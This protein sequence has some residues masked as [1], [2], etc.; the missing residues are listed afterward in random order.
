MLSFLLLLACACAPD[1]SLLTEDPA[2][3]DRRPAFLEDLP[4]EEP[5]DT[6]DPRDVCPGG[7]LDFRALQTGATGIAHVPVFAPGPDD[8]VICAALCEDAWM[9]VWVSADTACSAEEALPYTITAGSG[10]ALCF[11]LAGGEPS[12]WRTRCPVQHSPDS[13]QVLEVTW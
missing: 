3:A 2:T 4:G 9:D 6:A 8:G 11:E 10:A 12:S 13:G 1:P 5:V 7:L